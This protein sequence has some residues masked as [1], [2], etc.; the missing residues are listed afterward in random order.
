MAAVFNPA[1]R[2]LLGIEGG[3]T[4]TVALFTDGNGV[5]IRRFESGPTNLKLLDDPRLLRELR[6]IAASLGR[7]DAVGIGLAG[8]WDE[9]DR[10]RIRRLAARVWKTTPCHATHDLDIALAAA[11][12]AKSGEGATTRVLIVSGTGSC[13]YGRTPTGGTAK[14]GGWGHLLGDQGSGYDIGLQ[15]LQQ[16]ASYYDRKRVWPPLGARF[17]RGLSLNRPNDLIDWAHAASKADIAGLALDVFAAWDDPD[18]IAASVL[19]QTARRLASDAAICAA[20]LAAP[21][22]V[23][24]FVLTGSVLLRQPRMLRLFSR[25][26]RGHWK[27]ALIR[28]LDRESAWGAV[29]LARLSLPDTPPDTRI[30]PAI[31]ESRLPVEE[32]PV[33]RSAKMSPTEQRNPASI[34]LHRLPL[35]KAVELMLAE[36]AGIPA[37]L[38]RHRRSITQVIRL[39]ARAFRAGNRLFYAGAGTSG[40]LGVLDASEC[41]PTFSTPP[42]MVQG[43]MAGG[44]LALHS[45]V[46]GAEDDWAG[47]RSAI[48]F[49]GVGRGDVVVGIAASGTTPFVW[50]ALAEAKQRRAG[51]VLVCFNPH[52]EIPSELRPDYVLAIDVGP[53][54]LTGSTRLK[55]GTATKLLLNLFT[56]LAMVR[57]GKVRSNLM[58][59]LNPGNAKL[60]VRAARITSQLAGVSETSAREALLRSGWVIRKALQ[61][62]GA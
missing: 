7:P 21:R 20:K 41:P 40:R 31:G 27:N 8:A 29:E 28:P 11:P 2:R 35:E 17:L 57:I 3:A 13:C 49:R 38:L 6:L 25:N 39:V 14:V 62:L 26:L 5:L 18:G 37:K 33:V 59:D 46:E 50:G 44:S 47:G 52:L 16:V 58:I 55:A 1:E 42:D 61:R 4:H 45:S 22:A 12:T 48:H 9:P 23:V 60:R 19:Q 53:E 36:D 56:T 54:I 43:I 24:E 10:D 15:A 34:Q 30:H 32:T 51:T